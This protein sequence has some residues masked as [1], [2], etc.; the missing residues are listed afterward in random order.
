M[1][2][3]SLLIPIMLILLLAFA[4]ADCRP[5]PAAPTARAPTVREE[6]NGR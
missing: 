3:Q 4:F 2:R 5:L 1:E 6:G